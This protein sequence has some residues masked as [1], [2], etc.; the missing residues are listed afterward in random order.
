MLW[1]YINNLRIWD[2]LEKQVGLLRLLQFYQKKQQIHFGITF[3]FPFIIMAICAAV[4]FI[5]Y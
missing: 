2:W 3:N 4:N 5:E 1:W